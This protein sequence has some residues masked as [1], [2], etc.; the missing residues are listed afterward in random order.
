MDREYRNAIAEA[1]EAELAKPVD[2]NET[3]V[4]Q[5]DREDDPVQKRVRELRALQAAQPQRVGKEVK[6]F[7]L[8][9]GGK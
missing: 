7:F 1:V 2:P 4:R 3:L 6:K 9:L 8:N 5:P